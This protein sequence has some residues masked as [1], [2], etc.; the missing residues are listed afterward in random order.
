MKTKILE[1]DFKQLKKKR[2]YIKKLNN[3]LA[4]TIAT[5]TNN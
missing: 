5:N 3:G 1:S 2:D 4:N